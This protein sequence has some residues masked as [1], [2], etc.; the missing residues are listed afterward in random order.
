MARKRA[1][2]PTATQSRIA[3]HDGPPEIQFAGRRW[4]R[5]AAQPVGT[6]ELQAMKKRRDFAAYRFTTAG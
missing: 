6:D 4:L 1:A 2:P 5:G 3:Y